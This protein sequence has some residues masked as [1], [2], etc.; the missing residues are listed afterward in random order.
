LQFADRSIV[1]STFNVDRDF[2]VQLYYYNSI[3]D[4]HYG[5][6]GAISSGD[7]RN[8]VSSDRGLAYTGRVELLPL[9]TFSNDG[10]YFEGDLAREPEPKISVGLSY[11]SNQ[12]ATRTGGQLGTLLYEPRDINTQMIDFLIKYNG[13][14]LAAEY[15]HRRSSNPVTTNGM[16]DISYV[17]AGRGFNSQGGYLFKNNVELA[18]RFSEVRPT[19]DISIHEPRVRHYTIG[20]SKY[21]RGHR[22]KLQTDLTYEENTALQPGPPLQ[23]N[24][25]LRFQIEAGI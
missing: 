11:S 14:S 21:I 19:D 23:D 25:Q 6:R 24:W 2:G 18:A 20:A 15:L 22:L 17:Y 16:G 8:I 1:N 10:D 13:W 9:G 3:N 4:F 5:L 12:N 7:G